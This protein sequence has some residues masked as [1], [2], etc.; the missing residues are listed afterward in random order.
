MD[1]VGVLAPGDGGSPLKYVR[2]TALREDFLMPML[3][4]MAL[5]ILGIGLFFYL[6]FWTAFPIYIA[7]IIFSGLVYYGM[8]AGMRGKVQSGKEKMIGQE[9]LV[10]EDI[11]PEG[12]VEYGNEIWSA[13][14]DGRKISRGAKVRICGFQGMRLFV[15]VSGCGKS[16]NGNP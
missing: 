2:G 8:F 7:L 11:D 14:A 9:A 15:D 6:P 16:E 1:E 4:A 10:I 13:V 5:P 12:R 3:I